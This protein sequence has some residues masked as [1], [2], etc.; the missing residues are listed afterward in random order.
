MRPWPW[1]VAKT[2]DRTSFST[3]AARI[4]TESGKP[5]FVLRLPMWGRFTARAR[6][7]W[8]CFVD[9]Q[10]IPVIAPMGVFPSENAPV[11]FQT[12][13]FPLSHSHFAYRCLSCHCGGPVGPYEEPTGFHRGGKHSQCLLFRRSPRLSVVHINSPY[14]LSADPSVKELLSF[15]RDC[16]GLR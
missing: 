12:I 3:S 13:R 4:G 5:L 11:P 16:S 7:L 14:R 15:G 6:P 1:I 2:T 10:I 8:R 9:G